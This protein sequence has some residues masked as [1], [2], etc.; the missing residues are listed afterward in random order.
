MGM[1]TVI[2][3]VYKAENYLDECV[4]SVINQSYDDI[5]IILV[6]DGSPDNSGALCDKYAAQYKNVRVI[7]KQNSGQSDARNAGLLVAN[8]KYIYFLDSDDYITTD[9]IDS[10]LSSKNYS[11]RVRY[12]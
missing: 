2:I 3:P 12:R 9:A 8:G 7:H 11:R 1:V 6:D 5:E 4:K 10:F